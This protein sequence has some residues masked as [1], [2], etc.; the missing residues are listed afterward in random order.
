[1]APFEAQR[2]G[3]LRHVPA[4]FLKLAENEFALVGAARFV[5]SGIELLRTLGYAAEKLRRQVVRLDARLRAHNH[6]PLH[7]VSQ[8]AH[9]PRPR[10]AQQDFHR[11]IT[12]FPHFLSVGGAEFAQKIS[13]ER[14]NIFSSIAQGRDV[15]GNHV[16][17][18][19]EILA[20][21][22][23]RNL[24]IEILIGCGDDAHIHAQSFV[25]PDTLEALLLEDAQNFRLRAQAHI[26]D[27]VQEERS[28]VGFLKFPRFVLGGARKTALEMSEELGLDQLFRNGRA[29]HFYE[30]SLAAQACGMQRVSD[31]FL[32]G[33]ALAINQNAAAR[34]RSHGDLL[35]Q[36]LHRHAV[37]DHLIA[38]A[39]LGTQQLVFFFQSPLL[40]RVSNENNYF[41]KRKRL[42]DEIEST[43]LSGSHGGFDRAV[44]GNHDNRRRPRRRLQAAQCFEPVHSRKPNVQEHDFQIAGTGAVQRL[45]GGS[46]SFDVIALLL[47]NRGKRFA[48]SGLVIHNQKVRFGGHQAASVPLWSATEAGVNS[49]TG[50][51]T[52]KREPAGRLSS[53]WMLPPCSATMRAAMARPKP[54]P[55]S[56]VEKCGRNSLSL[57]SGE[58][59]W[60][61]SE[62]Q[63]SMVSASKCARVETTIS[64]QLEFSRAS[65]ALSMRF[66]IT[67]R[68]NAPSARTV[69]RFSARAVL[70]RMPS[71][72]PE[73]TSNASL[74]MVFAFVGKSFAVGKRTNC[75]NSF[76][77][78][79]SVETSRSISR[80]HS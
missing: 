35:A 13:R 65:A 17:P 47:E 24:L 12:E 11:R 7:E 14:W 41:F 64:R 8:F 78:A 5:Q 58:M 42:F 54:V 57:S 37:A 29:V 21:S 9:I 71:S 66:T 52:R 10:K 76:T 62:T 40:N 32:A 74:T 23:A 34:R 4:V 68:S 39:Q 72:R 69:G 16:K 3:R 45:L 30:G 2:G 80:E 73:N 48:D 36:R 31:E 15:K 77:R 51:S 25:G 56:L 27:F 53:T 75:E 19:E 20:K 60:P 70:S 43:Q 59:P 46:H 6:Q 55:R 50:S 44:A 1:M 28:A 26:A 67:L 63:I 61:V 18:V 49:A 79:A 33:A 22:A 38:M